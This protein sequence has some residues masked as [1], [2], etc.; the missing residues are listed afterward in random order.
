MASAV[1]VGDCVLQQL[2]HYFSASA[3]TT[4]AGMILYDADEL[5]RVVL[6]AAVLLG[7]LW[8]DREIILSFGS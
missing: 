1:V 3:D 5:L 4:D 7:G 6:L 8:N 2:S